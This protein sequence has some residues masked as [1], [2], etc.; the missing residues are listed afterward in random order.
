MTLVK[1]NR[2]AFA[3]KLTEI[4]GQ[5]KSELEAENR[6]ELDRRAAAVAAFGTAM[7]QA[8]QAMQQQQEIYQQQQLLNRSYAPIHTSCSQIGAFTNCTTR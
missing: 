2:I 7:Q 1:Q 8:G 6:E 5:M 4:I 3:A